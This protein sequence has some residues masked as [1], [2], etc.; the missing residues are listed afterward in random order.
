MSLFPRVLRPDGGGAVKSDFKIKHLPGLHVQEIDVNDPR[1]TYD[2]PPA[3]NCDNSLS[4]DSARLMNFATNTISSDPVV[5]P[6]RQIAVLNC[7][8]PNVMTA[9][10]TRNLAV[11]LAKKKLVSPVAFHNCGR[12]RDYIVRFIDALARRR[13]DAT[14]SCMVISRFKS[15]GTQLRFGQTPG[16]LPCARTAKVMDLVNEEEWSTTSWSLPGQRFQQKAFHTLAGTHTR[17]STPYL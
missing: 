7:A 17:S 16:T 13:L 14:P 3:L 5:V 6:G 10:I 9:E 2:G 1:Y 11:R 15:C 4:M 12:P 8:T